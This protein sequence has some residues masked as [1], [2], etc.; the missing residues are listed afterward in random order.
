MTVAVRPVASLRELEAWVRFPR[1]LVYPLVSPW[2][3]PLDQDVLRLLDRSANPFFRQGDAQPL[4]AYDADGRLVG[5]I[6]A[7]V[8]HPHNERHG[9]RTAFFGFFEC[10]DQPEAATALVQAAARVGAG[11]DCDTLRGPFNLT[12]MQEMGILVDGFEYPPAVDQTYTSPHYPRLLEAAG[13]TRIFPHA[14][15]RIDDV[16]QV[17]LDGLLGERHRVLTVERRLRVR[18]ARMGHFEQELETLRLLLNESF[19]E[20]PHFVPLTADELLFQVGAYR[21]YLDPNLLLVAEMDGVP[22][23]FLL[24]VP[25]FNPLLKRLN[26]SMS[27][28]RVLEL[29]PAAARWLWQRDACLIIQ[30]VERRLQGQGVMR[31]LHARLLRNLRQRRYRGLSVT[32][33][34]EENRRSGESIRALGGRP[35]HHL[36]LYEGAISELV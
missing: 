8:Y 16:R 19:A 10:L 9:E 14:T 17:N 33:I 25:D 1:R 7:Q 26:G 28:R 34:D 2:V 36:V 18:S 5:R 27:P 32:W 21:A 24:A 29:L 30:G 15:W 3:P 31:V 20:L 12:A 22:R 11:W 4:L 6:L 35:R 13:L 23:G